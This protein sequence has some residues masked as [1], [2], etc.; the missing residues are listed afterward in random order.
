[1]ILGNVYGLCQVVGEIM[2]R[3]DGVH[4]GSRQDITWTHESWVPYPVAELLCLLEA[5][6][7]F[8]SRLIDSDTVKHTRELVSVLGGVDHLRGC[9][10]HLNVHAVER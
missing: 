1:V 4:G 10:E 2:L 9:T 6:E 8:P 5:G 7:F 3:I